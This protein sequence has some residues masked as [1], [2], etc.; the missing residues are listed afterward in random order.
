[1]D[2]WKPEHHINMHIYTNRVIVT[3][4]ERLLIK[5]T[6]LKFVDSGCTLN[7]EFTWTR[8]FCVYG[9]N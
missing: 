4:F 7:F 5:N 9:N 6:E 1:M 8:G 2:C 3:D